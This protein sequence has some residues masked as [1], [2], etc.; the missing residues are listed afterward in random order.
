MGDQAA[1][2]KLQLVGFQ[3]DKFITNQPRVRKQTQIHMETKRILSLLIISEISRGLAELQIW[4]SFVHISE[5]LCIVTG[6]QG[7]TTPVQLLQIQ[8][9]CDT[10][11]AHTLHSPCV[12]PA[13]LQS[14][15]LCS[16]GLSTDFEGLPQNG[17]SPFSSSQQTTPKTRR[18]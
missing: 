3:V 4:N 17:S 15:L 14:T 1:A 12:K 11:R 6:A 13:E 7:C 5:D 9:R 8:Q 16:F 2:K 18:T 10:V